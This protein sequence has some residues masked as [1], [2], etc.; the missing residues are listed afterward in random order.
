MVKDWNGNNEVRVLSS[1][2]VAQ[3]LRQD[4]HQASTS[5]PVMRSDGPTTHMPLLCFCSV[6]W[7]CFSS[8]A[9]RR[10][11]KEKS[12]RKS[13]QAVLLKGAWRQD[14]CSMPRNACLCT[15]NELQTEEVQKR[16]LLGRNEPLH[17]TSPRNPRIWC[18][19]IRNS[20]LDLRIL[21]SSN[22]LRAAA[23]WNK[24]LDKPVFFR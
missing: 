18:V 11:C 4:S 23:S 15:V 16:Q 21:S 6:P 7:L 13:M 3:S 5:G 8:V 17:S 9:R 20:L 14:E 24:G 10:G 19:L 12:G 2:A 1:T 22:L